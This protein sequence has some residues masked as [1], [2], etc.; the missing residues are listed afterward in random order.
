MSNAI[1]TAVRT[2]LQAWS[3]PNPD[4]RASLLEACFAGD[5]RVVTNHRVID[6]RQAL[7]QVM[8]RVSAKFAHLRLTGPIDVGRKTFRFCGVAEH[9]DGTVAEHF[10]A[11]EVDAD[12]KIAFVLTF[13]SSLSEDDVFVGE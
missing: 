10:E 4:V 5:G 1:E 6:G 11:G 13:P 2:Y 3:E 9:C 8:T 12:G 7:G